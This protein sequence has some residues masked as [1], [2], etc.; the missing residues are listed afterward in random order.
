MPRDEDSG[1]NVRLR[2]EWFY[3]QRA[4]P[5]KHIPPGA[6]MKAL[7]QLRRMES[8]QGR[9]LKEQTGGSLST[10]PATTGTTMATA[11]SS[12]PWTLIG[13]QP[14][15][16]PFAFNPVSGR[17]TALAVDPTNPK[18]VYLGGAEGGVWKS[19]DGGQTWTP[20]TDNQPS[21]AV[22]SIAIDPENPQ[23]IYVGTGEQDFANY[24]YAG[25]GILKSTDGGSG[26]TQVKSVFVGPFGSDSPYCGGAYIGSIA[27]DPGN[28]QVILAAAT[29][30]CSLG[31]GIYRST[32]GGA[33][34]SEVLGST[35]TPY[36]VTSLVFDPT[37]GN[38]VYAAVAASSSSDLDGIWK[39]TNA[40]LNWTLDNG[41]G[42]SLFPGSSA[43]RISLAIAPSS[44]ATLYAGAASAS[45]NSESLLGVFKTTDGGA[46]WTQL[47]TAPQYCSPQGSTGQCYFDNV[48][49]VSPSDPNAVL[50]GGSTTISSSGY[51]GTLYLSLDGGSSWTD[52]TK[53]SGGNAIHPDM[54]A[55]AFSKDGTTMYVGN[56]GGVWS[57]SFGSTGVGTWT[58]LNQSLALTQFYPGMSID[59]TDPDNAFAGSQDNG[60]QEYSGSL[61]WNYVGCGDGGQ[62]AFD[63]S[64]LNTLYVSCAYTPPNTNPDGTPADFLFKLTPTTATPA[65]SGIDGTDNGAFIPPLTMDPS[66]PN[67]LYFG[68]YRIYQTT[69]GG[70][71][72][73][74]ISGD[75]TY[76]TQGILSTISTI[77]VAPSD[78]NTVYV[79][80]NDGRLWVTTNAALGE[81]W[82]YTAYGTPNRSV[83]AI[84]VNPTNAQTAYAT[85]SGYS[86]FNGDTLG[87]VFETTNGSTTWTDISGNLPNVP[88]NDIVIDPDMPGTLYIGTD[89]GVF[90]TSDG[91]TTWAPIG[92]G[93]PAVVIMSLKLQHAT[94]ILRAASYGRSAWDIQLPA[95]VGPTAVLSTPTLD[96]AP[97]QVGTTS[98]AQTVTLTNN[99]STALA[100]SNIAA[101]SGFAETNTCGTSLAAG[102]NCTIS[103]TFAPATFGSQTGTVTINDNAASGSQQLVTLHGSAFSGTV[104]LSPTSL[105]FGNQTVGTTSAAQTVTLTNSSTAPLTIESYGASLPFAMTTDCP[106]QPNTLAGGA[107]C[108]LSATFSPSDIGDIGQVVGQVS[109]TDSAED[110]PQ[111]IPVTGTGTGPLVSLSP[112]PLVFGNQEVGTTSAAQ[113]ATLTNTGNADLTITG[114]ITGTG[115]FTPSDDCPRAPSTIPPGATCTISV[116]FAPTTWGQAVG[117]IEIDDNTLSGAQYLYTQGYAYSGTPAVSPAS[118]NFVAAMGTTSNP[119]TVTLTDSASSPL[120][121]TSISSGRPARFIVTNKSCPLSPSALAAGANC[122]VSVAFSPSYVGLL[123][124]NLLV[125]TSG[126]PGTAT[127]ALSGRT[128]NPDF[129]LTVANG[130]SSTASVTAGGSANYSVTATPVEGFNQAV[131]LSCSGAP[132]LATCTVSPNSVTLDGTDAQ[133]VKVTVT[134]T[135]PGLVPP[136]P[137]GGPPGPGGSAAH[138]WWI[139]LL[140]LTALLALAFERR[141][142]SVLLAGAVLLAAIA[143]SCGGGSGGGG[144]GNS[145]PGTSAGTYTLT[146]TGTS[147]SLTRKATVTLAF[148]LLPLAFTAES[149]G[150]RFQPGK[151]TASQSHPSREPRSSTREWRP[152]HAFPAVGSPVEVVRSPRDT[153]GAA[154]SR[155]L[156]P[157]Y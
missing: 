60:I 82:I 57:T 85:F 10:A 30:D 108:H 144:G 53:D 69:D 44:P 35:Q 99:S 45:S 154:A 62:T 139:A 3:Q 51:A 151:R 54:H 130:T 80:T 106:L 135:A 79:G 147:G 47:T 118:L 143:L 121:I 61:E 66:N 52:I 146:V 4:Y 145:S 89:I 73:T 117:S 81:S 24:N 91:G 131:S 49:A 20:L 19:T 63:Y 8:Q 12:T 84:V 77:A 14:T 98:S 15:T 126:V 6:R 155:S 93:L 38:N 94:R 100:I 25:A 78:S 59:P 26:W 83:T 40:G 88:V 64:D 46:S 96:F 136:G 127:V 153:V 119:Q 104:S 27:V 23:T 5:H 70:A 149:R 22:G 74:P 124:D 90:S 142:R 43:A 116:A 21:L 92:T 34:W 41:S 37:N 65:D 67:T 120:Y 112:Q 102:A 32:D 1:E 87:H 115:P 55:L 72:W 140:M 103:V 114:I 111:T 105:A 36:L 148:R 113:T 42:T 75:L 39:S 68:T 157:Q 86:G 109:I 97:R 128:P 33:S 58:D 156:S 16:T 137:N 122:T 133:N 7:E 123:D 31:S 152:R 107:S 134:T 18:I 17:V 2:Q 129:T 13:P 110:S 11:L 125:D 28:S 76:M 141:R 48:V 71:D 29:F 150:A 101:S 56:D 138:D 9:R 132:W 95:P 50:L